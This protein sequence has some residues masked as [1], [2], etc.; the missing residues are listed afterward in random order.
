MSRITD[1]LRHLFSAGET[2]ETIRAELAD[3][4]REVAI[5]TFVR[6]GLV[7]QDETTLAALRKLQDAD[8]AALATV[9]R[10]PRAAPVTIAVAPPTGPAADPI[11]A[12][13]AAG[14]ISYTA[15]ALAAEAAPQ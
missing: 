5:E 11:D 9:L 4:H 10:A 1:A 6:E 12:L 15:A 2:V 7:G 13:A 8:P 14:G 3:V